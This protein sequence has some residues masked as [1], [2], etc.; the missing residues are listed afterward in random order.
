MTDDSN[1]NS[2]DPTEIKQSDYDPLSLYKEGLE[3]YKHLL[4][5]LPE[6]ANYKAVIPVYDSLKEIYYHIYRQEDDKGG[7]I[8]DI[9]Q[10][11][12]IEDI[13]RSLDGFKITRIFHDLH[14]KRIGSNYATYSFPEPSVQNILKKIKTEIEQKDGQRDDGDRLKNIIDEIHKTVLEINDIFEEVYYLLVPESSSLNDKIDFRKQVVTYLINVS[15]SGNR[16]EAA[17]LTFPYLEKKLKK[18]NIKSS[19]T[20]EDDTSKARIFENVQNIIHS[21]RIKTDLSNSDSGKRIFIPPHYFNK[22]GDSEFIDM[23]RRPIL[24][25]ANP[26]QPLFSFLPLTDTYKMMDNFHTS[27]SEDVLRGIKRDDLI[28]RLSEEIEKEKSLLDGLVTENEKEKE[29]IKTTRNA[30]NEQR[31]KLFKK[32]KDKKGGD[33]KKADQENTGQKRKA[34]VDINTLDSAS[35]SSRI[36]YILNKIQYIINQK[37]SVI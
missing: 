18:L 5:M 14:L 25:A 16:D 30:L 7:A 31:D 35:I 32:I 10:I 26:A 36:D 24:E 23:Y 8:E 20:D 19:K 6:F 4:D 21:L 3:K 37:K 29:Y 12:T 15:A 2:D 27:F 9:L 22:Y 13:L 1:A 11:L 34:I 28:L 17:K 33:G